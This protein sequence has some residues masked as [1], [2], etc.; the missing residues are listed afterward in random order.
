VWS[1]AVTRRRDGVLV[2]VGL[3]DGSVRLWRFSPDDGRGT[4][5]GARPGAHVVPDDP[6][7]DCVT[8]SADGNLLVS[9]GEDGVLRV[10]DVSGDRPP[11]TEVGRLTLEEG[12]RINGVQFSP[13]EPRLVAA[14][15]NDGSA[16]LLDVAAAGSVSPRARL[17][18]VG[19][20][21]PEHSTGGASSAVYRVAFSPDGRWLATS[22]HDPRVRLW[23]VASAR[24]DRVRPVQVLDGMS[25][26]VHA[27]TFTSSTADG[28]PVYL[29]AGGG[30]EDHKLR[31][32]QLVDGRA[33]VLTNLAGTTDQVTGVRFVGPHDG[34]LVAV[35]LD[36][37]VRTWDFDPVRLRRHLCQ[38]TDPQISA[39]DWTHEVG[40]GLSYDPP[41]P[42]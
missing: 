1:V 12:H 32:W 11:L 10:W 13:T 31:V 25:D 26:G 15:S 33:N 3:D 17:V 8:F 7:V 24:G 5:I 19:S 2:A 16:V 34:A 27:L 38:D 6:G 35:S 40:T 9:G 36:G 20:S 28:D 18:V 23:E 30:S 21:D 39:S 41:C 4:E 14:A 22:G 29:V 37:L 42:A